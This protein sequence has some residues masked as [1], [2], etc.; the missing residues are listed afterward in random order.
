MRL[1]TKDLEIELRPAIADDVPLLLSFIRQMA[2]FEKLETTATETSLREALF[3]DR[4]AAST[5]IA[6]A[7]GQPAAYAVYFFT[8]ATMVG[9]RGLWLDDLFVKPEF[10]GRGVGAALMSYLADLAVQCDCGR[11]EWAVLDWNRNAIGFYQR[12]GAALLDDWLVCRLDGDALRE[13]ARFVS[14]ADTDRRS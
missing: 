8:F 14:L 11:F 7:D 13:V 3:G 2:E 10:R 5:L 6:F 1:R 9:K 4:P 12:L